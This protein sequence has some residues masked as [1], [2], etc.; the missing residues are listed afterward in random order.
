MRMIGVVLDIIF[1]KFIQIEHLNKT[2]LYFQA[3]ALRMQLQLNWLPLNLITLSPY[4]FSSSSKL[5]VIAI[6][7]TTVK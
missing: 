7:D 2:I 5:S 3:K 6:F 4:Y 1:N